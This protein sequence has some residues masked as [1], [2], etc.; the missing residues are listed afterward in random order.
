L[1]GR[2]DSNYSISTQILLF[3]RSDRRNRALPTS[4]EK[5]VSALPGREALLG[6]AR[7]ARKFGPRPPRLAQDHRGHWPGRSFPPFSKSSSPERRTS[8]RGPDGARAWRQR[9]DG[10]EDP[11]A[12]ARPPGVIRR[13]R[14]RPS[15]WRRRVE[16]APLAGDGSPRRSCPSFPGVGHRPRSR[17]SAWRPRVAALPL[18]G[19]SSP[20][21]RRHRSPSRP[22]RDPMAFLVLHSGTRWLLFFTLRDPIAFLFCTAWLKL[23]RTPN[24][25][26]TELGSAHTTYQTHHNITHLYKVGLATLSLYEVK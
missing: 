1:V 20:R 19:D 17:P 13:P 8:T 26:P 22:S 3:G 10:G 16:A 6:R 9:P 24:M 15:S 18:S 21:R 11:T 2:L 4:H 14:S 5:G 7:L 25:I 12:T 23:D